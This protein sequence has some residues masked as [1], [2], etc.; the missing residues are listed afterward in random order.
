M[1]EDRKFFY[2][3]EDDYKPW[4]TIT[5]TGYFKGG[6]FDVLT[7]S[8][9]RV[10]GPKNSVRMVTENSFVGGHTP[11]VQLSSDG[12]SRGIEQEGLELTQGGKYDGRIVAAGN[13]QRCRLQVSLIWGEGES[14]CDTRTIDLESAEYKTFPLQF[15]AKSAAKKRLS[16]NCWHGKRF[17]QNRNGLS[18]AR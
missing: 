18:D 11:E 2:P 10:I 14:E 1:L 15:T 8:P 16:A 5:D 12:K 4:S 7:G 9:W 6:D 13:S 3:I 17:V